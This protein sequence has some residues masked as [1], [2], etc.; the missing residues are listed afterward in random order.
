LAVAVVARKL[1][2]VG[3]GHAHEARVAALVRTIGPAFGVGAGE[4]E[5]RAALDERLVLLLEGGAAEPLVEPVGQATC[6]VA[7]LQGAHPGVVDAVVHGF[8]LRGSHRGITIM[9]QR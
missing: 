6:V 4:E 7:V 1:E 8:V 5:Q 2:L 9:R 3:A